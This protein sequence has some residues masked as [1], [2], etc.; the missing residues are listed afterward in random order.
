[1]ACLGALCFCAAV[2]VGA[3]VHEGMHLEFAHKASGGGGG[4]GSEGRDWQ[5][6]LDALSGGQRT[7]V[8]LTVVV[9]VSAASCCCFLCCTCGRYSGGLYRCN[10][11]STAPLVTPAISALHSCR[12]RRR[13]CRRRWRV[14]APL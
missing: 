4:G 12:R 7:M 14:V 9:A 8:S 13:F 6:G 5:S 11:S 3:E 1:M 10:A 2:Q